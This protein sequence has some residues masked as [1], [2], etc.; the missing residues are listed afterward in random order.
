MRSSH[1]EITTDSRIHVRRSTRCYRSSQSSGIKA[2][3]IKRCNSETKE[4][5]RRIFNERFAGRGVHTSDLERNSNKGDPQ[6]RVTLKMLTIIAQYAHYQCCT[7]CL[8]QLYTHDSFHFRQMPAS[9]SGWFQA[10]P[11]N[12]GSSDGIYI[13]MEQRCREWCVPL[14]IST[15]DFM[16]AFD[17]IKH[18]VLWTSLE[19]RVSD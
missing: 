6:K 2:E 7:L 12:D 10:K 1:E 15:T 18:S 4:W 19:R 5:I 11:P 3:H 8:R 16:K 9:R 13:M 14:Y 17:R